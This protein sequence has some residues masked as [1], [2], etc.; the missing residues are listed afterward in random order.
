VTSGD[1]HRILPFR[2]RG[3]RT[4]FASGGGAKGHEP[5]D[6]SRYESR[7]EEPDDF[8]H[9]MIMNAFAFAAAILLTAAGVWLAIAIT[10]LRKNQ[11]CVLMS[12]RD[13]GVVAGRG[14]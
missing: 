4:N 10:D 8:R 1:E 11:D 5:D 9:R 14:G 12:R 6:L 3:R 7:E 2:P 13:C